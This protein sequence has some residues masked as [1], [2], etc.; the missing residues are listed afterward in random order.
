[1]LVAF[2]LLA[3]AQTSDAPRAPLLVP[4]V[5]ADERAAMEQKYGPRNAEAPDVG[6]ARLFVAGSGVFI[7]L[8]IVTLIGSFVASTYAVPCTGF[9][10]LGPTYQF[11]PR[12]ATPG[13][14]VGGAVVM[15]GAI[16]LIISIRHLVA[17][18]TA[19]ETYDLLHQ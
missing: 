6:S 9:I 14:V 11:D 12:R 8:G 17:I 7:G 15:A 19:A 16:A 2:W 18:I 1:M 10:C 13:W 5:T 4:P 3:A